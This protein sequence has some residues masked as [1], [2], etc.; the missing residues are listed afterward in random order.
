MIPIELREQ[1]QSKLKIGGASFYYQ[2]K[3]I[4]ENLGYTCSKEIAAYVLASE[5]GIDP[6]PYIKGDEMADYRQAIQMRRT[7][8]IPLTP[9]SSP[10]PEIKTISKDSTTTPKKLVIQIQDMD[11]FNV[12][13]L[14]RSTIDDAREMTKIYPVIYLFENSVREFIK[15]VLDKRSSNWWD[16]VNENIKKRVENRKK[17]ETQNAYHGQSRIHSIQYVDFDDLRN[18]IQSNAKIFNDY[19]P[20]NNVEYIQQKLRELKDSRNILMHCNPLTETD[21]IRVKVYFTDWQNLLKA[22]REKDNKEE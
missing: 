2:I 21:M 5:N 22:I 13:N 12:P 16:G 8:L 1:I 6:M 18:I 10:A 20:D 7:P 19:M 14:T 3:R 4:R 15:E 11:E 9:P 17:T